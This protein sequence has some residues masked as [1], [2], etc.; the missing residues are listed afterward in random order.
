MKW[1]LWAFSAHLV[2]G[3]AALAVGLGLAGVP[4]VALAAVLVGVFWFYSA[5][6]GTHGMET[7]FLMAALLAVAAGFYWFPFPLALGLVV[8]VALLGAWD[9]DFFLQRLRT[10]ER[11]DREAALGVAH[12]RR[13]LPAEAIGLV[14]GFVAMVAHTS[15]PL[16]LA[17]V[18]IFLAVIGVSQVVLFVRRQIE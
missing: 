12:L 13:L 17:I 4:L 1:V 8:T 5:A 10:A 14:L 18:L 6:N 3:I 2:V 9:L 16:W 11:I 15:V 7:F